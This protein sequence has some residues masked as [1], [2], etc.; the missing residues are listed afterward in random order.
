LY[1]LDA[2][3][4]GALALAENFELAPRDLVYIDASGLA[5]WNRTLSLLIP[6]SLTSAV[7][8]GKQ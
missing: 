3:D 6:G 5:N 4:T 1:Q 7:S 8:A 2:R